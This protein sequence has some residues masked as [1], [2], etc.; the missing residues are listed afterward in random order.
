MTSSTEYPTASASVV[1]SRN[2][3][4]IF[5]AASEGDKGRMTRSMELG[6]GYLSSDFDSE[7]A[8][9][10]SAAMCHFFHAQEEG[11]TEEQIAYHIR[12]ASGFSDLALGKR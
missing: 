5:A 12:L 3:A 10:A 11:K 9:N 4:D 7:A 8:S 2:F 6:Y 1:F